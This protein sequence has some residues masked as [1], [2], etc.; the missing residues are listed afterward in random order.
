MCGC[1]LERAK[2][3]FDLTFDLVAYDW[4]KISCLAFDT[5]G[6][7]F[8]VFIGFCFDIFV[9]VY[10]LFRDVVSNSPMFHTNLGLDN[11]GRKG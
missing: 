2:H 5:F 11:N 7:D 4:N 10:D 1:F 8:C 9:L 3:A 6:L